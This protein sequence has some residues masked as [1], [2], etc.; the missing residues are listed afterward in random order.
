MREGLYSNA[1]ADIA[2]C[3]NNIGVTYIDLGEREQESTLI[4]LL[5]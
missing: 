4:K 1:H 5:S 3:V 2:D